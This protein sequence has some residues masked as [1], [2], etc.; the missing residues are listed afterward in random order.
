MNAV[1]DQQKLNQLRESGILSLE[2]TA[3]YID[4]LLIAENTTTGIKRI[5]NNVEPSN[6]RI[7]KG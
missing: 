3:Y 5:M 4:G 1:I 6:K 7:L 2:E